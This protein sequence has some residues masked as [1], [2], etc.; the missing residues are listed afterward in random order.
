MAVN[1]ATTQDF[2]PVKEIKQGVVILKQGGW[3]NILMASSINFDLMS[4]EEREAV[5][6]Q[7]QNFLNSLDFEIQ[8]LVQSRTLNLK[9]YLRQLEELESK[10]TNEL[11]KMQA[12]EY[13]DFIESLVKMAN[14]ISKNF[15]I[16]VPYYPPFKTEMSEKEFQRHKTQLNLRSQYVI[17]GLRSTGVNAVLLN[18]EEIVELLWGFFNPDKINQETI[19][20]FPPIE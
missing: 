6:Y 17:N 11:L 5:I 20:A 16:I 13:R 4:Q 19:P 14:L 12:I 10:Q 8:I 9:P 2:L 15:Y 3:R 1:Q 18:S 7:F